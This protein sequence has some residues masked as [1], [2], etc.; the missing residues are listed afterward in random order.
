[1]VQVCNTADLQ[2]NVCRVHC[3][4][5]SASKEVNG[6]DKEEAKLLTVMNLGAGHFFS[7]IDSTWPVS[8]VWISRGSMLQTTR[9][10]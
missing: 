10:T 1:M 6:E 7:P 8:H 3:F 2:P 4:N 5:F 9:R